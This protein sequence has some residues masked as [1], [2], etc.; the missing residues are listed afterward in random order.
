MNSKIIFK[1]NLLLLH[2]EHG[3]LTEWL[4]SGLQNRLR[5]FEPT[6]RSEGAR[7]ASAEQSATQSSLSDY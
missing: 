3:R 4:G 7:E 2:S 1:R 6:E 5:R